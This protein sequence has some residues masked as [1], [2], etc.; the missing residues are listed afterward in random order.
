MARYASEAHD[1]ATQH[2]LPI[3]IPYTDLI[4][5]LSQL[6]QPVS[7]LHAMA[8][9]DKA[10]ACIEVLLTQHSAYLTAWV[11][12][13]ARACLEHGGIQDGL[14]A[15]MRIEERV[16]TGER[17]MEPEYLRL[18]ARLQLAKAPDNILP[19]Q[20]MLREALALAYKQ[21]AQ[22]FVADIERDILALK[23]MQLPH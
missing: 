17:W 23:N 7:S 16:N 6:M 2:H 21:D 20:Q 12:L 4:T 15:L 14:D 11:V 8:Y 22:T 10:K 9:L 13:Y 18:R 19:S 5:A 1:Y 3:W